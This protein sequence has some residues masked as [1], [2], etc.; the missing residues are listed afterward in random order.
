MPDGSLID[1][2]AMVESE[3]DAQSILEAFRDAAENGL[4]GILDVEEDQLVSI[5][6]VGN[7]HSAIVDAPSTSV[8]AG[9]QV[10]VIAW[11]DNEMGYAARLVD[12][13]EKIS[14]T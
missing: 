14:Q 1:L 3:V 13:S 9:H 4:R 2:S 8:L 5:D 6:I 11:Y 7:P 12:L 10:R